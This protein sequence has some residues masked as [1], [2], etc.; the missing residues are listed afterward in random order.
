MILYYL[1]VIVLMIGQ[2]S[3]ASLIFADFT[4]S[5][6]GELAWYLGKDLQE[7]GIVVVFWLTLLGSNLARIVMDKL[8]QELTNTWLGVFAAVSDVV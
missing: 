2:H 6:N 3:F 1:A 4:G 5:L 8:S 7:F